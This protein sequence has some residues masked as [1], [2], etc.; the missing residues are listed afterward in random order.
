[1]RQE[2]NPFPFGRVMVYDY[3]MFCSNCGKEVYEASNFCSSCGTPLIKEEEKAE[4]TSLPRGLYIIAGPGGAGLLLNNFKFVSEER[5][6]ELMKGDK[7]VGKEEMVLL[8]FNE[9]WIARNYMK[10]YNIEGGQ[11]MQILGQERWDEEIERSKNNN[12][13]KAVLNICILDKVHEC[14]QVCFELEQERDFKEFEK[15][16]IDCNFIGQGYNLETL[17]DK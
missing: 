13:H 17:F 9:A 8:V 3:N 16:L 6:Q 2:I 12:V 15:K 1:M 5:I 11:V 4:E 10:K 7:S 14:A